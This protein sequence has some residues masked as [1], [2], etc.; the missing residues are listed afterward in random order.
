MTN[1]HH[2]IRPK[3]E[4]AVISPVM[5]I[6]GG[7]LA[8]LL[9]VIAMVVALTNENDLEDGEILFATTTPAPLPTYASGATLAEGDTLYTVEET[10]FSF[11]AA[12]DSLNAEQTLARC[13]EV[14][15]S[16]QTENSDAVYLE[17]DE[18][19]WVYARLNDAEKGWNGWL[20][21]DSLSPERPADCG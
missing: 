5:V 13:T 9:L 10:A 19:Y 21:L 6:G 17:N 4:T 7:L 11:A 20:P 14:T 18:I 16:R 12:A 15:V 8:G 3:S 1:Q 2:K